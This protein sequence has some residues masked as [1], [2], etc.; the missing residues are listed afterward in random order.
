[1][2]KLTRLLAAFLLAYCLPPPAFCQEQPEAPVHRSQK[3]IGQRMIAFDEPYGYFEES[4]ASKGFRKGQY[5]MAI[6]Q[7]PEEL[8]DYASRLLS[9][10]IAEC[11]N[12]QG[13]FF[14]Y[15]DFA[16]KQ[17]PRVS[18]CA[19]QDGRISVI[20]FKP[21]S[22]L[23]LQTGLP[24]HLFFVVWKVWGVADSKPGIVSDKL[25][26]KAVLAAKTFS[27]EIAL[28]GNATIQDL[29]AKSAP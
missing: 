3:N 21:A 27:M 18:S 22:A 29:P 6:A 2:K 20:A 1:M 4:D 10:A 7:S 23:S 14:H 19:R 9:N 25:Q 26:E 11:Q 28:M 15:S 5:K 12:S 16:F 13:V 24:A 8:Q 17:A